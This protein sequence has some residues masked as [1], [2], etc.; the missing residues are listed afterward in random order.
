M[1]AAAPHV[2]VL[3]ATYNG[4]E[5]LPRQLDSLSAQTHENWRLWV[6]D[7]GS[8]DATLD[9]LRR[10][11]EV[12]GA[13][14]LHISPGPQ[15]GFQHNFLS[16]TAREEISADYYAWSDQ[17]D[18]WLPEKLARALERLGS[19]NADGQPALYCGRTIWIDGQGRE[20]GLSPLM[21]HCPPSFKNALVQCM[22]GANTMVFNQAARALIAAQPGLAVTTHDWWAY[23][24]VTG[25]GGLVFYDREP[26]VRYRQHGGNLI[27]KNRGLR[28]RWNRLRKV[29]TGDWRHLVGRQLAALQ[30]AAG[31]LTPENRRRLEA[32]ASL[33]QLRNP[34]RRFNRFRVCGFRRQNPLEQAAVYLAVIFN[35]L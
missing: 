12:W 1:T 19:L 27:G 32:L 6:S 24:L 26:M 28:P 23:Q 4:A 5:F 8:T 35:R 29:L 9:I 20:V 21:N 18:I 7:D 14:K 2:A 30:K 17:D 34:L 22:G 31:R 13:E 16:L 11:Q 33:R 15:K 10:Y 3:M 25:C